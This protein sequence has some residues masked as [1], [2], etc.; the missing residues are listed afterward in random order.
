MIIIIPASVQSNLLISLFNVHIS[1]GW[2][3]MTAISVTLQPS[4]GLCCSNPIYPIIKQYLHTCHFEFFVSAAVKRLR[5][6]AN[7]NDIDTG[8]NSEVMPWCKRM[9]GGCVFR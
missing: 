2:E 8:M 3:L 6:A 7:S 1:H 9:F 5:E 4:T